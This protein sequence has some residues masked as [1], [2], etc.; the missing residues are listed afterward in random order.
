MINSDALPLKIENL[1][2]E[3]DTE[4]GP[5]KAVRDVSLTI[6]RQESFGLVGESGS[7]KST[8]ALGAIRYL[9]ANGRIS[10]GRVFLLGQCLNEMSQLDLCRIW[11][12]NIGMVYQNPGAALN[13]SLTIG[14]QIA[15]SAQIHQALSGK[16][17]LNKAVEML[18]KVAM[19][20][21][22]AIIKLHPHQLSGG[23]L[24]RCIIAMALIN[25][26]DLL[27]L[28][29]PT[30]ALD[31]TTQ[32]VVLDLVGELKQVYNSGILYIT[33]DL[34]VVAKI[35]DRV[36]VMY[37]G[38]LLEVGETRKIFRNAL[39]PYTLSLLGCIPHFDPGF[40]KCTLISLPGRIP[41]LSE[42]PSGCI[43]APRCLFVEEPC[44]TERPALVEVKPGHWS[45]CRRWS[46]LPKKL[47]EID[48]PRKFEKPQNTATLLRAEKIHKHYR[49]HGSFLSLRRGEG[50][51]TRA[52][53]GVSLDIPKGF[54]L[55]IVGESGCGKTT[56]MRTIIGL[57]APTSGQAILNQ[58]QLGLTTSHRPPKILQKIQMVFQNPDVSLNPRQTVAQAIQRPM[59]LF[60]GLDRRRIQEKT[61]EL[62]EAVNLPASYAHRFP[63]ELSGGEKQ[64]VAIARAFAAN[65][66]LV[67]LDEPLSA[68]D[69]SVQAGLINLLFDL[70]T[71]N[72]TTYLF[73]SHDLAAV[74]H[75]SDPVAV[76]YLG[77]VVQTSEADDI[78]HPPYHPY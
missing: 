6:R 61:Y 9:A 41:R 37:A 2:I 56:L 15:E 40:R 72:Q 42:I 52:V 4:Q 62:L 5:V 63:G 59:V 39:H 64:R 65:P 8:L 57:L 10:N 76:M 16:E 17:S 19:P 36:G 58:E 53:N 24:Q 60:S 13:P 14:R 46:D 70:Q 73:I 32:A 27:I 33:H 23:M 54:T 28:D 25:N 44:L 1:D 29:E 21:P 50:K 51:V 77:E 74:Y 26:P 3:Y 49:T 71:R 55:G 20:N 30:T 78:F 43:F 69:V 18:N 48:Q 35:S 45:A 34:A 68:L 12:K 22:L 66:E 38:N 47:E 7:G 31:V 67:L 75:I 11:G